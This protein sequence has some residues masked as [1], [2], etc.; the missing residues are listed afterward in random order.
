MPETEESQLEIFPSKGI[1]SIK[2]LSKM[3]GS[4]ERTIIKKLNEKNIQMLKLGKYHKTWFL[5]L[6]DLFEE[7]K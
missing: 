2:T 6:E 4:D 3:M 5:R 7:S 1:V